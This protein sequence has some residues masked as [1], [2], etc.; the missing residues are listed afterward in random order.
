MKHYAL[1]VLTDGRADCLAQ[2]L[3]SAD[4]MLRPAGPLSR[5]I[6]DDSGDLAY[7]IEL[8]ARYPRYTHVHHQGKLGFC[9]A[10]RSLWANIPEGTDYVFHLEDDF[11]FERRVFLRDMTTVL[12]ANPRI[13]E[14]TLMRQ[15]WN[16]TEIEAG[17]VMQVNPEAFTPCTDGM[18]FW[19]EHRLYFS[20]NPSLYRVD[21][22]R[23][24]WP[25]GPGCEGKFGIALLKDPE[26][27][28]AVWGDSA[29]GPWVSHI[30][31]ERVGVGY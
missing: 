3:A 19:S 14:I 20:T 24:P 6:I 18:N 22:T 31:K 4:K 27:R 13:A 17:G 8:E 15:A 2:T 28:F 23:K 21:L 1:M 12:D 9:G 10:V 11:I 16:P 30:G 25:E 26:L 5:T 29:D 7:G